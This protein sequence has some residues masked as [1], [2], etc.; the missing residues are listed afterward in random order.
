MYPRNRNTPAIGIT[1]QWGITQQRI[2]YYY[3]TSCGVWTTKTS[4]YERTNIYYYDE[5]YELV[6]S[7]PFKS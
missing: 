5:F 7:F 1:Q 2:H 6:I 4:N 3:M